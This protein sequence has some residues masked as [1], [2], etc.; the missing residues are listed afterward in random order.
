MGKV[1]QSITELIGRTP[2]LQLNGFAKQE[3]LQKQTEY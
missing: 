1:N 2:L 3:L